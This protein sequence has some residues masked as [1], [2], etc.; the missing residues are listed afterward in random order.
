MDSKSITDY[1]MCLLRRKRGKQLL[2]HFDE[3]LAIANTIA[4]QNSTMDDKTIFKEAERI[5]KVNRKIV[6]DAE[7]EYKTSL[8]ANVDLGRVAENYEKAA[9]AEQE[10]WDSKST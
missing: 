9:Q 2:C 4:N 10:A 3:I 1:K 5:F 6:N 7:K 8:L